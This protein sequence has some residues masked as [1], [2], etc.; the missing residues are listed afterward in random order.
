MKKNEKVEE[1]IKPDTQHDEWE[2]IVTDKQW[3]DFL[4]WCREQEKCTHE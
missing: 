1:L 4:A 3:D 2:K